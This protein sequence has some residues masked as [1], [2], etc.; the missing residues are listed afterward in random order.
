M[1]EALPLV[2]DDLSEPL[3]YPAEAFVSREYAEAPAR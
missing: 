3:I 2:S 1:N